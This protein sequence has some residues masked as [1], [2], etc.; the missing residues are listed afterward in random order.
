MNRYSRS[1]LLFVAFAVLMLCSCSDSYESGLAKK[2]E[3]SRG[4]LM[5]KIKGGW[6]GQTIGVT[7]GGPT[8]FLYNGCMIPDSGEIPWGDPDYVN[9]WRE[10]LPGL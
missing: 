6:A 4:Q 8:E 1:K 2:V 9:C 5:D 3:F 10:K 7:Y